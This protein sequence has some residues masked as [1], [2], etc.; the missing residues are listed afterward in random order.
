M[1]QGKCINCYILLITDFD[2]FMKIFLFV[3]QAAQIFAN[4]QKRLANCK[5]V[6]IATFDKRHKFFSPGDDSHHGL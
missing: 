4:L 5:L 2:V 6:Q 1:K 3:C